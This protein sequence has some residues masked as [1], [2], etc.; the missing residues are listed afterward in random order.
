[1]YSGDSW[2]HVYVIVPLGDE[3]NF[4]VID[5]VVSEFNYEKKYT[6]KMD[7]TMSLNG[8]NVAVL[9]GVS[10]NDHYNAVMANSLTGLCAS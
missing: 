5:G 10:S 3:N 8:I 2:Q 1:M 4:C 7:F 9:S 6:K